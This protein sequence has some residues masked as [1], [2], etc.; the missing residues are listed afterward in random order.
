MP[1]LVL[2][3]LTR[4]AIRVRG[5]VDYFALPEGAAQAYKAGDLLVTDG[6]SRVFIAV[7]A[8]NDLTDSGAELLGMAMQDASGTT[9]NSQKV[10]MFTER[11]EIALPV[12][13]ATA[14]SAVTADTEVG[15]VYVLT[16]ETTGGWVWS[17][18]TASNPM[19]QM[20]EIADSYDG[21]KMS[22]GGRYNPM[23]GRFL[24]GVLAGSSGKVWS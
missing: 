22:T 1:D 21:I 24:R 3:D 18:D 10:M 8:G 4:Q 13:H 15:N 14:A 20:M 23:W 9:D 17:I 2:A 6:A 11:T 16:N 12:F 5:P 19:A 7:A